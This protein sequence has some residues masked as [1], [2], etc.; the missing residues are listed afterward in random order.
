MGTIVQ[1]QP[2]QEDAAA[3]T[4]AILEKIGQLYQQKLR[5]KEELPKVLSQLVHAGEND[6]VLRAIS[7]WGSGE[8]EPHEVLTMVEQ[9]AAV[10][11]VKPVGDRPL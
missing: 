10:A 2:R 1:F 3:K 11:G 9:V 4:E 5:A 7:L 6:L 8:M